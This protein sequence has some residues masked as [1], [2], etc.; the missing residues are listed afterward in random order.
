MN[1]YYYCHLT[2]FVDLDDSC[3]V[4]FY[5]GPFWPFLIY[6]LN[7]GNNILY[8]IILCTYH[9]KQFYIFVIKNIEV[10]NLIIICK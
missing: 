7:F 5:F 1:D 4:F 2:I 6:F 10:D 8:E 3:I 9:C